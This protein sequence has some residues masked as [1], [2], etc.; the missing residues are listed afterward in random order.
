MAAALSGVVSANVPGYM[1]ARVQLVGNRLHCVNEVANEVARLTELEARSAGHQLA[2]QR[3]QLGAREH[4]AHA[5]VRTAT[6]ERDVTV[7]SAG[8]VELLGVVELALIT[9]GRREQRH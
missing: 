8:D 5:E 1:S 2:E 4:A 9:I 7:R 6:A 3:S